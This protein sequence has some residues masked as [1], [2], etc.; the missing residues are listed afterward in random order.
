MNEH[1]IK[2]LDDKLIENSIFRIPLYQRPYSW[3]EQHIEQLLIDLS[4]HEP[5]DKKYFVG[6][7]V[8]SQASKENDKTT[9]DVIDGQQRLT[10]IFLISTLAREGKLFSSLKLSY[11]IRKEDKEFLEELRAENGEVNKCKTEN[12][13]NPQFKSN[14]N[15]IRKFLNEKKY[16]KQDLCELLAKVNLVFTILPENTDITK[17]FEIMNNRGKQLEKHQIL[18]AKFLNRLNGKT[19]KYAKIWDACSNMDVYIEDF[20]FKD[21]EDKK[22]EFRKKLLT[23][24]SIESIS[25]DNNTEANSTIIE[26]LKPESKGEEKDSTESFKEY[27]SIVKFPIFLLHCLKLYAKNDITL[28]DNKLIEHFNN[29]FFNGKTLPDKQKEFMN[30]M[31]KQ[32]ILFDYFIFKRDSSENKKPFFEEIILNE[33]NSFKTNNELL[34]IQLLFNISSNYQSQEWLSVVLQWLN[35]NFK[36]ENNKIAD[37]FYSDYLK[38]LECFDRE[39]AKERL[40]NGTLIDKINS[41]LKQ[42]NTACDDDKNFEYKLNEILHQGTSTPHYWFYKLD[43]LLW[44]D[45]NILNQ[46]SKRFEKFDKSNFRLS[47]LNSIEHIHPQSKCKEWEEQN[48]DKCTKVDCFGNLALISNHMN[49]ALNAQEG[50]NKRQDIQKQLN[51]GT[52]ESLKMILVYSKYEKW[53]QEE[54][55]THQKEM[56]NLLCCDLGFKNDNTECKSEE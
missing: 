18:K 27:S 8:L 55:D 14:I 3:K 50:Q 25:S 15:T 56:I 4:N 39:L 24:F 11:E 36:I 19:A 34:M 48:V 44:K 9:Y 49:S 12:S 33:K 5:K 46:L 43:Y 17:Y 41:Y 40:C 21:A 45:K 23:D 51:N 13:A 30:F 42:E 35:T 38:F 7:I 1:I 28:D 26:L 10:T 6:N 37:N 54:C 22:A 53:T 32:R 52:I 16:E 2:K 47:R 29:N 31:L 20:L